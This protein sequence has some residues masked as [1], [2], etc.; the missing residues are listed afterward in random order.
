M[1]K[2]LNHTSRFVFPLLVLCI[3]VL[4]GCETFRTP[5]QRQSDAARQQ[6]NARMADEKFHR[7]QGRV[8]S[9]EMENSR[10]TQEIQQLR[11]ELRATNS[12][13]G[14]MDRN[15]KTLEARQASE[16]KAL[17]RNVE[18]LINKSVGTSSSSSSRSNRGSGY[19]HVVEPGHTLSAIASLY[20]TSVSSI[21]KANKLKSDQIYV[22]QKLFIPQ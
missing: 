14:Q 21:K 9:T 8:E 7:V 5:Q 1:K 22:G 2:N 6:A 16:M 4:S 13:L 11:N 20:G 18:K 10:L 12:Q 15:L 17:I 19:E 3:G